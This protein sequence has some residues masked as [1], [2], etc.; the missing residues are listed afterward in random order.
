ML[1]LNNVFNQAC[2]LIEER[3]I[4]YTPSHKI[5][6]EFSSPPPSAPPSKSKSEAK[7]S[8]KMPEVDLSQE[9]NVNQVI[10]DA[11][12]IMVEFLLNIAV[13]H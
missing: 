11:L 8:P 13:K 5:L 7:N 9:T 10:D 6:P 3:H 2:N 4:P 12:E 1:F